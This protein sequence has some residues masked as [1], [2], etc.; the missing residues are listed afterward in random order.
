M[1][2]FLLIILFLISAANAA[3]EPNAP[4][5]IIA[6]QDGFMIDGFDGRISTKGNL[7]YF[8]PFESLTDGRGSLSAGTEVRIL[9]S[10]MLEKLSAAL[11]GKS[12]N[13]RIWGKF[14]KYQNV[15][16]IYLSYFLPVAEVNQPSAEEMESTDPN[17]EKIIPDDVLALLRPKRI[18]NLAEISRPL[19]TE[20]DAIISDRTGFLKRKGQDYYFAFDALGRKID[21]L[22]LPLLNCQALEDIAKLQSL[23]VEPLRFTISAIVTVYKG[24][25]YMLLQRAERAYNHGNFSK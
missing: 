14:T 12:K 11:T 9:P 3:N 17:E 8:S 22:S 4:H 15:N 21:S 23:T 5:R 10:S 2:R 16:F 20:S 1:K 24:K 25:N 7:C 18:I 13:F 6:L 19:S